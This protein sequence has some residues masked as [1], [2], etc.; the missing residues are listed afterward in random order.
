MHLLT[1]TGL[2]ATPKSLVALAP[3]PT[4]LPSDDGPWPPLVD[5]QEW[6]TFRMDKRRLEH[7]GGRLLLG[8][9]LEAW[10]G[11]LSTTRSTSEVEVRRDE[12]RAPH[13]HWLPGTWR[14]DPLPSISIAHSEGMAAVALVE[15]GWRI[16]VDLEPLERV[17]AREAW[18]LFASEDERRGFAEPNQALRAWVAKEAVQKALGLGMHLNPRGILVPDDGPVRVGNDTVEVR[19]LATDHHLLALALVQQ[20]RRPADPEEDLLDATRQAMMADPT[21]TIGCSTQRRGC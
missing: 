11:P 13:L 20:E 19:R 9:A 10:W 12:H 8:A 17:I 7:L 21:W 16:G 5:P 1:S 18:D 4:T 14:R 2:P 6:S 15:H 3:L